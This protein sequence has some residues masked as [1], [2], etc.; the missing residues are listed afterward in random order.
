M[1]NKLETD[2]KII[3]KFVESIYSPDKIDIIKDENNG[4]VFIDLYFNEIKE[5]IWGYDNNMYGKLTMAIRKSIDNYL[6]IK[7]EG[8]Q[9]NDLSNYEVH[10]IVINVYVKSK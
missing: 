2:I 5:T 3:T 9:P 10:P 7:T 8:W 4:R 1:E 6:S